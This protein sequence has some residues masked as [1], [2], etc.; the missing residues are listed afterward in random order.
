MV[1]VSLICF[2]KALFLKIYEYLLSIKSMLQ[3]L[4]WKVCPYKAK[5]L[6]I[7]ISLLL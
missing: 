7:S 2:S 3:G 4:Y 5:T 1:L 6:K